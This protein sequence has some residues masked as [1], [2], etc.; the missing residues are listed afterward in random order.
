MK[1]A[2][3]D[4]S[5]G[6]NVIASYLRDQGGSTAIE[7]GLLTALISVVVIASMTSVGT[8]LT[9]TFTSVTTGLANN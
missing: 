2:I 7:Y 8:K 6:G 5:S 9:T 3:S 4:H 1:S